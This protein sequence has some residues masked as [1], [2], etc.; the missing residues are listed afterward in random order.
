MKYN[1][2]ICMAF[3][4]SLFAGT[5][6]YAQQ[7][8]KKVPLGKA[9]TFRENIQTKLRT[10]AN[11]KFRSMIDLNV[12]NN[13]TLKL[14]VTYR[15][16]K[17]A[18]STYL[19]GEVAGMKGSSFV[20][21]ADGSDV[22]GNIIIR[23]EN[24]AYEYT[25]DA[26]GNAFIERVDINKVLCVNYEKMPTPAKSHVDANASVMALTNLQSFPGARGCVL[27]DFDGH[28]VSGTPWN[29]GNP[30][31][32]AP[33]GMSD[34]LV[35]EAWEVVAEDFRP[36]HLNITTN[37]AVF[38]SYPKNMRMRCI[39][40]PT[41]TAA[42]GAGGVAYI[43]SF[44]WNDDTPCWTFVLSGKGAGE[45]SSHE[46]GHTFG[47][48][49]D[50]RTNPS[51]GYFAGHGDWAPIMGVGYYE[52]ITQWSRGQYNFA[53]NTEDDLAKITSGTYNVGYRDDD[54]GNGTGSAT[55]IA[56]G[57]V[58]RSGIIERNTDID[59]FSFNSGSGTINLNINTVSRHGDLDIIA[60]LYNSSGG[61]IATSNPAGLNA[62][63]SA[64]V[65]AGT[66]YLSVDNTGA[67]NPATDGYSDYASLGSYFVTGSIP[68]ASNGV[69]T[70]YKDCNYAG[71]AVSVPAGDYTLSAL[72]S[73]GI[74]NDD[75]SSL[76][77]NAGYEV[78]LYEHDNY[79]GASI[80][81]TGDNSCLVG[82]GWND[83]AS[84]IRVRSAASASQTIQA[85]NYSAMLGV[86]TEVTTDAGGGSNVGWIETNDWMAYNSINFPSTGAYLIEY[87]VA[88]GGTGGTLS[89]D[90]NAGAI[91]LGQVGIPGTGGWQNW[92]T[93]SHTVNVTGGT[94]NVGVF[95]SAGG[96][97][98][99]WIRITRTGNAAREATPA[100]EE[101]GEEPIALFPNP[102]DDVLNIKL[103]KSLEGGRVTI[104]D[105][106][107][108]EVLL[109]QVK[110]G[111]INVSSLRPGIHLVVVQKDR[112][113]HSTRFEK[114]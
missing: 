8:F 72:V 49:H 63:L 25:T 102:T 24:R 42:P 73:R 14:S 92:T 20:I 11:A 36:F 66:Y 81:I 43:G 23:S 13:E 64:S 3:I 76:R 16:D 98:I 113:R 52:P 101:V 108:R 2:R 78:V 55:A 103:A 47:L 4:L 6:T 105:L 17:D 54:Y 59:F 21:N 75:I 41:N 67:G 58:N 40:T 46:I 60:R 38:N 5:L 96:W 12:G 110:E 77:V 74:V 48:G 93:V 95:A 26:N 91:V 62:S 29:N 53:N 104:Y 35:Q 97:N 19:V 112:L 80:T 45:A 7:S 89:L 70:F 106:T 44:N 22:K 100:F 31:N 94:Y 99:N 107:G 27:L 18:R 51:E 32:A 37:E 57:S 114:K 90:L 61:V 87:R 56:S 33:S 86:Q 39:I 82:A 111:Q 83:R 34:A 15:D 50:G 30:I 79:G 10:T 71:T 88:S 68:V 9:S 1:Y 69:A 65:S 28:Y 109:G 84:S 85:E